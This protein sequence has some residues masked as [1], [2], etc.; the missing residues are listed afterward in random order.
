[1]S[2]E[3]T[4]EEEEIIAIHDDGDGPLTP[5]QASM[6]VED[7]RLC[8]YVFESRREAFEWGLESANP[9]PAP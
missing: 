4:P 2:R 5:A 7:E 6:L 3:F 1:M 9:V 8:D